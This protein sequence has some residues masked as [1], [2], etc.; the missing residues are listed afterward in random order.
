M[1][2]IKITI[3]FEI[4]VHILIISIGISIAIFYKISVDAAYLNLSEFAKEETKKELKVDVLN[5]V[6]LLDEYRITRLEYYNSLEDK[7]F[8]D[9]EIDIKIKDEIQSLISNLITYNNKYF[10]VNEIINLDGGDNY[11]IRRIHQNLVATEG[12]YLSTNTL[13]IANNKPYERELEGIKSDGEIYQSYYFK[14]LVNDEIEEKL[15]YSVFYSPYNWIISSGIPY[16]DLLRIPDSFRSYYKTIFPI[17]IIID[18]LLIFLGCGF[19]ALYVKKR[20]IKDQKS[21]AD[22]QNKYKSEFLANMTHNLRTPMNAIV[23]LTELSKDENLTRE[24][25]ADYLSKIDISSKYLLT[26]INDILDISAI[27]DGKI[28]LEE[29]FFNLKDLIRPL[30]GLY[31]I[32]A[33]EKGI[34]FS[35]S[36]YNIHNESLIGDSFRLN[37]IVSNLLSNAFKFTEKGGN[38]NLDVF[39]ID[40]SDG[41]TRLK[42]VISDTGC[43]ID[44]EKQDLIFKKFE[45]ADSNIKSQFGGSGLGL[46]IV[47]NLAQMM[48][49]TIEI[50]DSSSKGTT[51]MFTVDLKITKS[52]E[53]CNI[54]ENNNLLIIEDKKTCDIIENYA[55]EIGFSC[56]SCYNQE[57]ALKKINLDIPYNFVIIKYDSTKIYL[58]ILEELKQRYL[59]YF[60]TIIF[61][62][63]EDQ[64]ISEIIKDNFILNKPVFKSELISILC[65]GEICKITEKKALVVDLTGMNILVVEDN[66]INQLVARKIIESKNG[67][68][69]LVS[70][71]KAAVDLFEKRG[72]NY[73]DLILMD[74]QMPIMDGFE[75]TKKIRESSLSYSQ[76]L[77]I[78]ALTANNTK[79]DLEACTS[80]GMNGYVSKPINLPHFLDL[81][82][83]IWDKK[84]RI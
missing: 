41:Q 59:N 18:T 13:D 63:E 17:F 67:S 35:F 33:K 20:K 25:V 22:K 7:P 45:Q 1:S 36:L 26:L 30:L 39:Q 34:N 84:N 6:S 48:K 49:G 42:F 24:E 66:E 56:E 15:S 68:V 55:T 69:E 19:F 47:K 12:D 21:I 2:K 54:S 44:C 61:S 80:V 32:K 58:S 14:N 76:D 73:Y 82:M 52:E 72:D 65:N 40:K 28:V 9:E 51:F 78:Y 64:V 16:R 57:M 37:Q 23:G 46:F 43:G 27:E 62:V 4:L 77:L 5:L 8:N 29:T 38:V 10:W 60:P 74:C 53:I 81:L 3:K 71:G 11:A 75:A 83:R 31:Q 79:K 50:V 70:N